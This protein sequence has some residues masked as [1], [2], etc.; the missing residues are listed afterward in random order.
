MTPF[1]QREMSLEE[2]SRAVEGSY[3]ALV[4]VRLREPL[5][6]QQGYLQSPAAIRQ[7]IGTRYG[8]SGPGEGAHSGSFSLTTLHGEDIRVPLQSVSYYR[9]LLPQ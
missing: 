4:L 8:L 3:N 6:G 5:S 1:N 9:V 7:I 2:I